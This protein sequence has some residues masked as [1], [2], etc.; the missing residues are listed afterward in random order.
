MP[1]NPQTKAKS[2]KPAPQEER[3]FKPCVHSK[4]PNTKPFAI[5]L[6]PKTKEK[7]YIKGLSK[8]SENKRLENM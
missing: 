6:L 5:F 3:I 8:L 2:G 4:I 7:R 1:L